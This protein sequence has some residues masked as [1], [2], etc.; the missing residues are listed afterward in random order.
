MP[1]LSFNP[2][3]KI[4]N[5]D[6]V[7]YLDDKK[8]AKVFTPDLWKLEQYEWQLL[9]IPG[10]FMSRHPQHKEIQPYLYKN[11][12]LGPAFTADGGWAF[13]RR[14]LG[15]LSY[16]IPLINR[17]KRTITGRIKGE[18]VAIRPRILRDL[19]EHYQNRKEFIR[20]RTSITIPYRKRT[21]FLGGEMITPELTHTIR[22]WMYVGVNSFWE[23][24]LD[25]GML[26]SP[27][28]HF[29]GSAEEWKWTA[30]RYFYY[31][32]IEYENSSTEMIEEDNTIHKQK[33][34][35]V[36]NVESN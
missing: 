23:P 20:Y 27:V 31:S 12:P 8:D 11:K 21:Y 29:E 35:T 26:F 18:V 30:G 24:Q 16:P 9:F 28:R 19:D 34:F 10:E 33:A 1:F 6:L 15:K 32:L 14:N 25:A 17:L 36:R 7:S 13:W 3:R 22:T 5:K 4:L 2:S